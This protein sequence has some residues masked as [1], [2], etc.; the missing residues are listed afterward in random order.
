[1]WFKVLFSF[2]AFFIILIGA[3]PSSAF[4]SVPPGS[5]P[6]AAIYAVKP[7]RPASTP[8]MAALFEDNF[9]Q[10]WPRWIAAGQEDPWSASELLL[11]RAILDN[12]LAALADVGLDGAKLLEGYR[13]KRLAGEFVRPEARIAALV[14]HSEQIISLGD[15]AFVR[16][17]GFYIYHELGHAVDH[18]LGRRMGDQFHEV[19]GSGYIET[20]GDRRW[21]T[22]D[23]YWLRPI[24]QEARGEA[25]ADAF[26]M[27]V[28]TV[29]GG[30]R[31][32]VF[33]GIS[34]QVDYDGIVAAVQ[35]ALEAG[36]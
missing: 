14:N 34:T 30:S 22:A 9:G 23:G 18:R 5:A 21:S 12:T 29:Y 13:F 4:E 28:S 15:A 24:A 36:G 32:P 31:R 33:A 26:G 10:E 16:Q 3:A 20:N 19:A 17:Q 2:V 1:M 35:E 8:S 27:W 25:T 6:T 7:E 11:V